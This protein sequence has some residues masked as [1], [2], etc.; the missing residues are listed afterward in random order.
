MSALP[1]RLAA[2]D[3]PTASGLSSVQT[4]SLGYEGIRQEG[5]IVTSGH[6]DDSPA[7]DPVEIR[8][9]WNEQRWP[10]PPEPLVYH[11]GWLCFG[12]SCVCGA[13]EAGR[14]EGQE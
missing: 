9:E 6:R 13:E 4:S 11:A 5:G 3:S 1:L 10:E 12:G 14:Q 2:P 8:R 7:Y